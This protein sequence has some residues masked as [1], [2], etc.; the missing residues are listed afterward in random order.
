MFA[1]GVVAAGPLSMISRLAVLF[2][3][4]TA[5]CSAPTGSLADIPNEYALT[6]CR[7]AEGKMERS[8]APIVTPILRNVSCQP[9]GLFGRG[10][11][12]IFEARA[13]SIFD[14]KVVPGTN[15]I[16]G[17]GKF[18]HLATSRPGD[19]K[20]WCA[21]DWSDNLNSRETGFEIY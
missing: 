7:L 9:D 17:T 11:S 10:L 3:F 8:Y 4:C 16:R 20:R 15:W 18:R 2:L 13:M 6:D 19:A 12:C 21:T 5:S 14:Q 1:D